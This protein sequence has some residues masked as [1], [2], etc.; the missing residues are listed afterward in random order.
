MFYFIIF[1]SFLFYDAEIQSSSRSTSTPTIA[2]NRLR[3]GNLTGDFD[4]VNSVSTVFFTFVDVL[5]L[6]VRK[7]TTK[8]DTRY[9]NGNPE[10]KNLFGKNPKTCKINIYESKETGFVNENRQNKTE[11]LNII[12]IARPR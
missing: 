2:H 6:I 12:K 1:F 7:T 9:V 10:M 8:P 5:R 11:I 4:V 3:D